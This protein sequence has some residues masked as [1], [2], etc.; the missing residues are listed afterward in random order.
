[1]KKTVSLLTV[2]LM[3]LSALV[4]CEVPI[5]TTT[6]NAADGTTTKT[7]GTETISIPGTLVAENFSF[8]T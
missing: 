8:A 6:T 2:I 4:G 7:T 1:M 3:L 5:D